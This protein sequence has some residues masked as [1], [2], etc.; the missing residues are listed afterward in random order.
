MKEKILIIGNGGWGTTLAILLLKK[1]FETILWGRSPEYVEYLKDKRENTKFLKG[2]AIPQGIRLTSDLSVADEEISLLV[3]AVPSVYLREVIEDLKPYYVSG[4][5]IVSV[6]KGIENG[7]YMRASEIIA[8]VLGKQPIAI[9]SGPSHAEE[10]ARELPTTVVVSSRNAELAGEIQDVFITDRFRVYTNSDEIGVELGGAAKNVIAIAAGICAGLEFGD[11][12]KAALLTRGLAE[13]TRLGLAMGANENTFNGLAGIGDLIT[14]CIS[15]YGRNLRVGE[16]I[17]KGEKLPEILRSM[18]QVA[19]GVTT[20]RSLLALA[21]KYN[22]DM[23]IARET[24][25]ILFEDKDP[26]EAVSDLMMRTPRS[27]EDRRWQIA[28]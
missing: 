19:E 27:E 24:Y 12:T 18:E 25:N 14:T 4:T 15:P 28:D 16:R 21:D 2:I 17:G 5:K 13:I 20:T 8:D 3:S 11:N 26:L 9:L 22:I 7:S 10:V 23:P 6:T 1:G